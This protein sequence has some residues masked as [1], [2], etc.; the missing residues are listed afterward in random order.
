MAPN[1][2]APGNYGFVDIGCGNNTRCL[3]QALGLNN[4]N[5]CVGLNPVS[6]TTGQKTAASRYFNTRFDLYTNAKNADPTV[7]SRTAA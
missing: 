3:E 1:A 2:L 4:N 6:T 5:K 7:Y